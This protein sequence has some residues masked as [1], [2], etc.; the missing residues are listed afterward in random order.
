[1]TPWGRHADAGVPGL[2]QYM[3]PDQALIVRP[4]QH[5]AFRGSAAELPGPIS[6]LFGT[7]EHR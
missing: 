4:D 1:M 5:I 3:D 2:E 7:G 6:T